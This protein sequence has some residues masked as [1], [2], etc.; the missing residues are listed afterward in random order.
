MAWDLTTAGRIENYAQRFQTFTASPCK[1]KKRVMAVK[2]VGAAGVSNLNA[3]TRPIRLHRKE[4]DQPTAKR[5]PVRSD[6]STPATEGMTSN[7]KTNK[8][9]AICTE[10]VTTMPK[11]P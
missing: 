2:M 7:A 3:A 1:I 5:T 9:P 6:A 4:N 8:T 10:E 11:V